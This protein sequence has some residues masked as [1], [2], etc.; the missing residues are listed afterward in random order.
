MTSLK[1]IKPNNLDIV[2]TRR[3]KGSV[4]KGRKSR[5]TMNNIGILAGKLSVYF[6]LIAIDKSLLLVEKRH[7]S[8]RRKERSPTVTKLDP[9]MC[10]VNNIG[11]NRHDS[12]KAK[13]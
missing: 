2:A 13:Y 12:I 10:L 4:N 11:L 1:A 9:G 3:A 7:Q 6:D 5:R 8:P